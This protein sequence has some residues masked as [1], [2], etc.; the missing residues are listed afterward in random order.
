MIKEDIIQYTF[1]LIIRAVS[2]NPKVDKLDAYERLDYSDRVQVIES[3]KKDIEDYFNTNSEL[4]I[5]FS[6]HIGDLINAI[7][8]VRNPRKTL[9]VETDVKIETKTKK[10]EKEKVTKSKS[11]VKED[12]I[13]NNEPVINS[14]Q[15]S[16]ELPSQL[17]P[18]LPQHSETP[19]SMNNAEDISKSE[20]EA[21]KIEDSSDEEE[22]V[23]TKTY[24]S[25][26]KLARHSV[27]YF[28]N[29]EA[30]SVNYTPKRKRKGMSSSIPIVDINQFEEA[31]KKL[32]HSAS[33]V[34]K[35][36]AL[37][38]CTPMHEKGLHLPS[39]ID[40]NHQSAVEQIRLN[41]MS[42]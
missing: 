22:I 36:K 17:V 30:L 31:D 39:I 26:G 23:V 37:P 35:R 20:S 5:L 29:R 14:S 12:A 2:T 15:N 4:L 28:M 9:S 7:T 3:T 16:D 18:T 13:N 42:S 6:E 1:E 38:L 8:S 41:Y 27:A 40:S 21:I 32:H 19:N 34:K 33:V 11:C 25:L 24:P 10:V